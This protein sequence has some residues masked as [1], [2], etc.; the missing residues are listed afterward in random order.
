[1]GIAD[2][3]TADEDHA[4]SPRP[5]RARLISFVT[6]VASIIVFDAL[7]SLMSFSVGNEAL[8]LIPLL[9]VAMFGLLCLLAGAAFIAFWN[10]EKLASLYFIASLIGCILI[11]LR[12]HMAVYQADFVRLEVN[13]SRYVADIEKS[14]AD[15]KIFSWFGGGGFAGAFFI[16][17]VFDARGTGEWTQVRKHLEAAERKILEAAR[18]EPFPAWL[19]DDRCKHSMEVMPDHFYVVTSVCDFF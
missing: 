19:T 15:L 11:G 16:D 17:L 5:Q 8:G 10:D 14:G 4:P 18:P 12:P 6:S 13:K 9:L 7:N 3:A 1:M 2:K